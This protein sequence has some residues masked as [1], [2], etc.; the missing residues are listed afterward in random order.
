MTLRSEA[1]P[2]RRR[3]R[4]G[5]RLRGMARGSLAEPPRA[6]LPATGGAHSWTAAGT[7]CP[8]RCR[9]RQTLAPWENPV[10]LL[11][12]G[13]YR[14]SFKRTFK[15][16]EGPRRQSHGCC[17]S[18]PTHTPEPAHCSTS[19]GSPKTPMHL[20]PLP[21]WASPAASCSLEGT[22]APWQP[23]PAPAV[24]QPSP[25]FGCSGQRSALA[26]IG[27]LLP[28]WPVQGQILPALTLVS[29]RVCQPNAGQLPPPF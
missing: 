22:G 19:Q 14:C 13:D 4:G 6:W 10:S 3:Q 18:Q 7:P 20:H 2:V 21:A 11:S 5:Q 12:K 25:S 28:N 9:A 16:G 8:L 24:A 23:D 1:T 17:P 26:G 27:R 29:C 15:R